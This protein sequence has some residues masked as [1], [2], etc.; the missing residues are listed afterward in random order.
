MRH[1]LGELGERGED[2]WEDL[3]ERGEHLW[4]DVRV[5]MDRIVRQY[6]VGNWN[7]GLF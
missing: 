3:R 1:V 4:G 2:A 5:V 7:Q 6:G